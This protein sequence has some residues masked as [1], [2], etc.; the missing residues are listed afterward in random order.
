MTYRVVHDGA[1]VTKNLSPDAKEAFRTLQ[2][3]DLLEI[4]EI[5]TLEAEKRVRGRL[6]AGGWISISN[7]ESGYAWAEVS[8]SE[9]LKY[10]VV[11]D[12]AVVSTDIETTSSKLRDLSD[13]DLVVFVDVWNLK[14][15][16]RI[17]G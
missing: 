8:A 17:R 14:E 2:E 3:Q 10:R 1:V 7:T 6:G 16:K 13:G 11:Q 5:Q 9:P 4:V 15:S 12:G